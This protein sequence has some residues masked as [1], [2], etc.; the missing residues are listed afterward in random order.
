MTIPL[1]DPPLVQL[2]GARQRDE[3]ASLT[4]D[5]ISQ[6]TRRALFFVVKKNLLVGQDGRGENADAATVQ[7][8]A[9]NI[10]VPS[11]FR[12][13]IASRLP[14]RGPLPETAANRAFAQ[15]IGGVGWEVLLMPITIR[16]RIIAVLFADNATMPLPDAA[17]HATTR[18]AG[19]A[20]ERLILEAKGR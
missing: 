15:S 9:I 6:M 12:D 7:K 11:I 5:Y 17:L 3:I 14:Y 20:Y 8:L 19:L 18:E 10:D 4:L 1:P 16:E 13:V 2:R